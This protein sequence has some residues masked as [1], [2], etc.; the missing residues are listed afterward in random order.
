MKIVVENS[1]MYCHILQHLK[2]V[3]YGRSVVLLRV[4]RFPPPRKL[5]STI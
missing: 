1:F 5:T 3:T 2:S 4:L